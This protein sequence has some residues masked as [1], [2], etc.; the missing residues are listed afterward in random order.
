MIQISRFVSTLLS[1]TCRCVVFDLDDTLYLERE[2]VRS[3]FRIVSEWMVRHHGVRGFDA[4]AWNL[5]AEGHRGDIFNRALICAGIV[6][7]EHIVQQLVSVYRAHVPEIR[8]LPDAEELLHRLKG[9]VFLALITDG[10]LESQRAKIDALRL[11]GMFDEII[12]TDEWGPEFS[13]PHPRSFQHVQQKLN[14]SGPECAY[15][16]DNPAKDFITP[17]ALD[18]TTIRVRRPLGLHVSREETEE[19]RSDLEL[20]D[21]RPISR[22][23]KSNTHNLI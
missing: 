4:K 20:V 16:A 22:N 8:L 17:K 7:S 14:V 18:W 5:F 15:I 19:N 2:Y 11:G 23:L 3:G 13:K 6:D 21:F 12:I 9:L 10:P 1:G